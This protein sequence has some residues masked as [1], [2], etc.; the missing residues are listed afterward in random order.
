MATEGTVT[1][2]EGM[3]GLYGKL[4]P[5]CSSLSSA[6]GPGGRSAS[7]ACSAPDLVSRGK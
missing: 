7:E 3:V 4:T 1:P 5:A 2:V 6:P